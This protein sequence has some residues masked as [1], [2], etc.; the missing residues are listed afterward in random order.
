MLWV[1]I[2]VGKFDDRVPEFALT[3][4]PTELG[5]SVELRDDQVQPVQHQQPGDPHAGV[6]G[7]GGQRVR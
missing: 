5:S 3:A 1:L 6:P 4:P 7:D 2:L